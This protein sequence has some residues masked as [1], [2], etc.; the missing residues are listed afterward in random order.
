[1]TEQECNE[2]QI[3]VP[4]D[5]Y[6]HYVGPGGEKNVPIVSVRYPW[7]TCA[8]VEHPV[9]V[10]DAG[11][12]IAAAE[13]VRAIRGLLRSDACNEKTKTR[14][15]RAAGSRADVCEVIQRAGANVK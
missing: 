7:I 8:E 4:S 15:D 2:L 11:K 10:R 3:A 6:P 1:M 13:E 14:I 9:L 12:I 5:N